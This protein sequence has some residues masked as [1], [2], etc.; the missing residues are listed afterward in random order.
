MGTHMTG[1]CKDGHHSLFLKLEDFQ[2]FQS[3]EEALDPDQADQLRQLRRS[4]SFRSISKHYHSLKAC[5]HLFQGKQVEA[6][7]LFN[8]QRDVIEDGRLCS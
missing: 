7:N 4:I 2:G 6:S 5:S 1:R 3:E 8:L